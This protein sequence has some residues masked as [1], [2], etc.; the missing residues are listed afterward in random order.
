VLGEDAGV[1]RAQAE[2]LKTI[3]KSSP[4]AINIRD[5]CGY[6]ALRAHLDIN[7]DRASLAELSSQ[8]IAIS[9]YSAVSGVQVGVVREGRNPIVRLMNYG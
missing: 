9:S 3:L 5:D 1:L 4:L 6:E 7:E 2:K 8:D